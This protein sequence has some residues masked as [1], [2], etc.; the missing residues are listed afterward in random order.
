[1]KVLN[2]SIPFNYILILPLCIL[3]L[4]THTVIMG[5][6]SL[7]KWF[8]LA[9]FLAYVASLALRRKK[10]EL[11]KPLE[12]N[13]WLVC[14]IY[15][16][17]GVVYSVDKDATLDYCITVAVYSI[18]L[19]W[20]MKVNFYQSVYKLLNI[21]LIICMATIYLNAVVHNLMTGPLSFLVAKGA[22]GEVGKDVQA[23]VY[24]GIFADRANAAFAMNVGFAISYSNFLT[25]Q[26]KK[27]LIPM[28][29]FFAAIFFTG[30]RMLFLVPIIMIFASLI[31]KSKKRRS[32]GI[33]LVLVFA[34]V[35]A[36]IAVSIFPQMA[37]FLEA[38]KGGDVTNGRS[39]ILWPIAF[40]MYNQ[41]PLF[42]VGLNTFN[43]VIQGSSHNDSNLS[44]WS[45]NAHN[46]YVQ[47][48]G[49]LGI[50]GSVLLVS[51]FV[52][53]FVITVKLLKRATLKK[54]YYLLT[55][56]MFLQVLWLVYGFSGNTFY[57]SPQLL[58]YIIA[59]GT[60]EAVK[61]EQKKNRH[62]NIS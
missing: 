2:R 37:R 60:M 5:T 19:F 59:L 52:I 12:V 50:V 47:F 29:L 27:H 35:I 24:S 16:F 20:N 18:F 6:Y 8:I 15:L 25:S 49:E 58:C 40:L 33:F 46:I 9:C 45:Y 22:I 21:L 3:L 51:A 56:S 32:Q 34:L 17:F 23:G 10:T 48:L 62:I 13:L 61:Y 38:G 11:F 28:V 54:H 30:K 43:S 42:G 26:K 1:M 41:S 39:T 31:F 7:L 53:F 14:I 4:N 55:L 57:Y 44:E 36:L